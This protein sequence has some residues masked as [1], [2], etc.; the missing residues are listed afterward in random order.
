MLNIFIIDPYFWEKRDIH[1]NRLNFLL[2][3]LRELD[4]NL[5]TKGSQLTLISG[6]PTDVMSKLAPI[7]SE[8]AFEID[9][10]PYARERDS[11]IEETLKEAGTSI[12]KSSGHTLLE[13]EDL[14][15]IGKLANNYNVFVNSISKFKIHEPCD[16]PSKLPGIPEG[17]DK[18][19]KELGLKIF[20]KIPSNLDDLLNRPNKVTTTFKGGEN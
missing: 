3:T 11:K 9:T 5:R 16:T 8:I 4:E 18:I 7:T 2:D 1:E 14:E 10:E 20:P 12:H 19:F 13:V 17:V 6:N 15:K